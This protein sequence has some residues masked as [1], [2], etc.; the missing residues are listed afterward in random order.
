[1]TTGILPCFKY[2]YSRYAP[3]ILCD[4]FQ[5]IND[6]MK[7]ISPVYEHMENTPFI[8]S[9]SAWTLDVATLYRTITYLIYYILF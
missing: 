2:Q 7:H 5:K 4:F 9:T 6:K 1:M 3:W 8:I